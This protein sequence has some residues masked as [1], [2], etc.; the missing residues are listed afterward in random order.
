MRKIII[1]LAVLL[2]LTSV[3]QA[4]AQSRPDEKLFH[5]AKI[6]IFDKDWESA[7]K[8]LEELLEKYPRS[9]FASQAVFYRSRCL[10]EQRGKELEALKAYKDYIR[11]K[12][13]SESL[14]EEAERA[15]IDIAFELYRAGKGSYLKEIEDRLSSPNKVI[16]YYAAFKLSYLTDKK[17]AGKGI[18]VLKEILLREK[19][20][21][22][23]DRAKIAL[24]RVNPD[25]LKE[26]D[27]EE[28]YEKKT[29]LLKI[30]VWEDGE[31][32]LKINIPWALAELV[33]GSMSEEEKALL[34][35]K[36]Y[37]WETI[38]RTLIEAGEIIHVEEKGKVIKIWIE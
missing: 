12:E 31:P 21:E 18:A 17:V 2:I 22:L 14:A 37:D 3:L 6:L 35:A 23:R 4:S 19:D 1:N 20:D 38:T 9:P 30:R 33:L 13:R 24:L 28:R 36:G 16:K 15:I 29:K 5:E 27:V 11:G 8:K 34:R 25:A 26:V 32:V 7:Q 10:Q